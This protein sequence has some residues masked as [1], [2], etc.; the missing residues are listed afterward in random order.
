V[1][2]DGLTS[3]VDA[4]GREHSVGREQ[5]SGIQ[6]ARIL[7]AMV[8][9]ASRR[10]VA[11]VTVAHVVAR[12]GVSRRTFYELFEDREDCFLA[13]LDQA[14]ERI[15]TVVVP[16]YE[17]GGQW[18]GKMRA[19]L[20]ALLELLDCEPDMGRL[21]IVE[22]LGA[23]PDA[24]GRRQNVLLQLIPTIDLGRAKG[25]TGDGPPPLTAEGVLG[26]VLSVLH[27]RLLTPERGPLLDLAGALTSMIVLPYLG[28]SAARRELS[29]PA[30]APRSAPYVR[31]ADPLRD[32]DM[33]LTYRT[34]RVLMAVAAHPGSS[35]RQVGIVAGMQDQGQ[36]SKLLSRLH[37][38]ELIENAG[39][40]PSKGA[41]NAWALTAKGRDIEAAIAQRIDR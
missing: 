29:R 15:A 34:V 12:S 39:V 3:G 18:Q 28:P 33:R 13:A 20:T 14:L 38:L 6:R 24:L 36:I 1:A 22:S 30:P 9:E 26:G 2:P 17:Q 25:K 27:S 19:A 4:L 41:P 23:G 11:N 31:A 10:G 5:V 35:N 16:A 37:R 21:L 7:A 8:Q 40:G 32:V